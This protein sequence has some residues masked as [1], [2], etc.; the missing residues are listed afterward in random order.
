MF[1]MKRNKI[2]PLQH[3]TAVLG[4][5]SPK[6]MGKH[7]ME[8]QGLYYTIK[9]NA[10]LRTLTIRAFDGGKL[11]AKYRTI[12]QTADDY[13]YYT[14]HATQSDIKQLLQTKYYYVIR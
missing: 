7:H 1:L 4:K 14:E 3:L 9:G 2:V 8:I 5:K 10:R 11:H 13:N 12:P 6:G